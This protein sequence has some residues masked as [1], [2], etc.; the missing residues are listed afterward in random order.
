MPT[1]TLFSYDLSPPLLICSI[2]RVLIL[3]GAVI[4][5]RVNGECSLDKLGDISEQGDKG[6]EF[7]EITGDGDTFEGT[8]RAC[9]NCELNSDW[10]NSESGGSK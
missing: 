10:S 5:L 9:S 6:G 2:F 1:S 7:R 4:L 3:S 8:I